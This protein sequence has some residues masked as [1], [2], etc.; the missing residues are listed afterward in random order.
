MSSIT[1]KDSSG[2]VV[3]KFEANADE[4]IGTQAQDEGAGIPFSCGVGACRTCVCKVEKG[5][6]HIN[7]EAVGPMH[8]M[9]DDDEMLACI[10]GLHTNIPEDAEI[11]FVSEN[12]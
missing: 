4:S 1:V 6:E 7:K 9:V 3:T 10:S 11:V 5:L 8:I 2:K 12:L